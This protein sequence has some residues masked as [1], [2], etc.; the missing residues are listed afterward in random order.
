[1]LSQQLAT[2]ATLKRVVTNFIGVIHELLYPLSTGTFEAI[3]KVEDIDCIGYPMDMR[4]LEEQQLGQVAAQLNF[5]SYRLL[6]P[7]PCSSGIRRRQ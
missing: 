5:S 4:K 2:V 7:T 1:M 6:T 3:F